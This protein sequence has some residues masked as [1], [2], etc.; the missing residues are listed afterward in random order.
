MDNIKIGVVILAWNH[1][2]DT[3]E[4]LDSMLRSVEISPIIVVVDNGSTD[5]TFETIEMLNEKRVKVVRSEKI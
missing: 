2:K 3:L 4:C 1:K 5:G